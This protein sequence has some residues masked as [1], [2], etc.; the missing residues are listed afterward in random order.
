[1]KAD[2]GRIAAI[3]RAWP[4]DLRLVLLHG[5]DASASHDY[6]EQIARPFA[7]PSNPMAIEFLTGAAVAADP[8]A[9]VAAAGA[10]SMFGDRTL[11]RVDGLDE[12]GVAAIEALLAS[13]A[14]NPVVAV[15]GS[16]KKGSKLLTLADSAPA[17]AALISYEPGLRDAVR[18]VGELAGGY[19]LRPSRDAAT[20][21]FEAS[22]GDRSLIRRELEKLCLYLDS[23]VETPRSLEITDVAAIGVG[24][25]DSDQFAL[26]A[27]I[28]GGRPAEAVALLSRLP[29]NVRIPVLRAVA[30]RFNLLLGLRSA[31]DNGTPAKTAVDAARPPIFWK[32][33]DA[34]AAEL[35]RWTSAALSHGLSDL[36]AA[37]RAIKSSGSLGDTMAD[38]AMLTLARRA[39]AAR[40]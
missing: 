11:V 17:I 13:P 18:L 19:G 15:A 30:R 3:A 31:V 23:S 34:V 10:M 4:A 37:E 9:L 6:A 35:S 27:A 28:S 14:G 36:L 16:L 39:A 12:N 24:A 1:M 29:G 7:D 5:A 2:A 20:A 25:G 38:S 8:Q 32:E 21:L 33:K 22:A 26:V 40:R